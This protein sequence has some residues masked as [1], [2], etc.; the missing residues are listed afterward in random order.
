MRFL[1]T[2]LLIGCTQ[3][4]PRVQGKVVDIWGQPVQDALV[5]VVGQHNRPTTD[6]EGRYWIPRD[7]GSWEM[8]AGAEGYIPAFSTVDVTAQTGQLPTL[9][10]WPKPTESGFYLVGP[11][12]Y[13]TLEPQPVLSK[14]NTLKM[15]R[16]L[17][18]VGEAAHRGPNLKV[19]FHTDLKQD[20]INRLGLELTRMEFIREAE[21]PAAVSTKVALNLYVASQSIPLQVT[22]LP[23]RS[24]Y[25]LEVAE[26]EA[27]T[28]A[29]HTQD[30][31]DDMPT[32]VFEQL[33]KE[34]RL[35]WG[36]Q[37]VR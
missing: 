19:L 17:D 28:Y 35:A 33:P 24:D 6:A 26:L 3:E 13:E 37:V 36:L 23:S 21:I 2:A 16:G 20:Q 30:I 34:H 14:G 1:I 5:I 7:E 15:H 10:L 12:T 29:L 27:G 31:L 11:G 9:Q 32:E 22:P 8:K 25:L 4:E 18:A